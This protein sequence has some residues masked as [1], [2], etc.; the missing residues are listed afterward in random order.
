MRKKKLEEWK[1]EEEETMLEKMAEDY[2]T[3][4]AKKGKTA[5][6]DNL[7][8]NEK[9]NWGTIRWPEKKRIS[10]EYEGEGGVW[11]GEKECTVLLMEKKLLS[12]VVGPSLLF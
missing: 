10:P 6:G 12:L 7:A 8:E 9:Q 11:Y 5:T 2:L 3:G 1:A 4:V